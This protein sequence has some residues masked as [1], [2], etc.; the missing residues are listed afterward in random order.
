[1][2][3]QQ[4]GPSISEDLPCDS[5]R[6]AW[7]LHFPKETSL[8]VLNNCD[9]WS[10]VPLDAGG[11]FDSEYRLLT[12][13]S[14]PGKFQE[15]AKIMWV[16]ERHSSDMQNIFSLTFLALLFSHFIYFSLRRNQEL[17]ALKLSLQ[18]LFPKFT[19]LIC[20]QQKDDTREMLW[21]V[22]SSKEFNHDHAHIRGKGPNKRG[23]RR[24][25]ERREGWRMNKPTT[26]V[27]VFA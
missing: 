8:L 4:E 7:G 15:Q 22:H 26:A 21:N 27:C 6:P 16:L 11:G 3:F 14:K 20:P 1:M 9:C 10:L 12:L 5:E 13:D 19:F 25:V 24:I 2:R 18:C 17:L 23:G